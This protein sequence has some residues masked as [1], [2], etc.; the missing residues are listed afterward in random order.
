VASLLFKLIVFKKDDS[1]YKDANFNS[2]ILMFKENDQFK[3]P[4]FVCDVNSIISLNEQT[5]NNVFDILK[6]ISFDHVATI[7]VVERK[8]ENKSFVEMIYMYDDNY[9]DFVYDDQC[10][11]FLSIS[12]ILN[13]YIEVNEHDKELI[14]D[15]SVAK[16]TRTGNVVG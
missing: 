8:E 6:L 2:L 10:Y 12:A 7:K 5:S 11:R 3:L 9:N 13:G 15:M 4:S 14:K 16:K 1:L